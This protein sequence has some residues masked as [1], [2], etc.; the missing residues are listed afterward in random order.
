MAKRSVWGAIGGCV[1]ACAAFGQDTPR[2]VEHAIGVTPT[3]IAPAVYAGHRAQRVGDWLEYQPGHGWGD[4]VFDCYGDWDRDGVPDGADW[5]G[6]G[7]ARWYLGSGFCNLFVTNDMTLPFG[8]MSDDGLY[9]LDLAWYWT[10]WGPST[11]EQCVIGVFT[12][13]SMPCEPDSLDYAGWL[14]DFG[15]LAGCPAGYYH[16]SLDLSGTGSWPIRWEASGSYVIAFLTNDG[17]E[18]ASCAQPMLWG[19]GD[20]TG[21]FVAPGT[22]GPNQF[23]EVYFSDGF[24]DEYECRDYALGVCPDPLGAM[25][26]FW[27][28]LC[29]APCHIVNCNWDNS[30]DTTDFLCYLN[31]WAVSDPDADLNNDDIVNVRDFIW[32]LDVWAECR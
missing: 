20:A 17:E 1:A 10:A 12:Q 3:R 13:D 26:R 5:C 6:L 14:I 27:G 24:H 8:T 21:D 7:A 2:L 31:L 30:I 28:T 9:R 29:C 25:L 32:F 19:T 22:Q 18:F 15:T 16:A 23:D 4:P 11:T